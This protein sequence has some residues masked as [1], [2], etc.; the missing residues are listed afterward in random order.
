MLGVYLYFMYDVL[1]IRNHERCAVSGFRLKIF[2]VYKL[3]IMER[4]CNLSTCMSYICTRV[5]QYSRYSC[6]TQVQE[7]SSTLVCTLY[8]PHWYRQA[9]YYGSLHDIVSIIDRA[10]VLF[11]KLKS[12]LWIGTVMA[13]LSDSDTVSI[14]VCYLIQAPCYLSTRVLEYSSTQAL[15]Q[16]SSA[17]TRVLVLRYWV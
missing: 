4:N 7:Y 16:C 8:R 6:S 14:T 5:L 10:S 15:L 12:L 1:L 9:Y 2:N 11:N 17:I 3:Q 13:E